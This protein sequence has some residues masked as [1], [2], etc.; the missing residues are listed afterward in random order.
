MDINNEDVQQNEVLIGNLAEEESLALK[1]LNESL[2]LPLVKVNRN[3]FLVKVF[4]KNVENLDELV[5]KGPVNFF[6][7]EDLDKTAQN[8]INAVVNQS[9]AVSFATG[10]PGG[11]AMAAT[12]PADIAQFYAYSIKLAQEISY[13]YGHEDIWNNQDELDDQAKN[14]LLL[15]LGIMLG[16]SSAGSMIR[17]MSSKLSVQAMKKIPQKALTKT[18]YYPVLKKVLGLFGTKLTKTTFS[19]GVSKVIPVVGGV[20]SGGLNYASMK[21][22]ANKLKDELGKGLEYN[23]EDYEKDIIII[24][25]VDAEENIESKDNESIKDKLIKK[26]PKKDNNKSNLFDE[27]ERAHKLLDS[28]IIDEEEFKQLKEKIMSK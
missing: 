6:T 10:V 7:K 12:I 28:G 20:V 14:T 22:M 23:E 26:I 2:K 1:V 13:I 4:G 11:L 16:V 18:F 19:K 25:N 3:E 15:Y 9:S 8:R 24:E 21:P 27:I 17:V 5:L